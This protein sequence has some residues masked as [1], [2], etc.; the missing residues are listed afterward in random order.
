V[1]GVD[2]DLDYIRWTDDIP[3]IELVI[4]PVLPAFCGDVGTPYETAEI[5][6]ERYVDVEDLGLFADE[7]RTCR[8]AGDATCGPKCIGEDR[9]A[10]GEWLSDG[11]A[12]ARR[13]GKNR[14]NSILAK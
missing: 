14:C 1:P 8:H 7:W 13:E 9:L 4:V 11:V 6:D 12:S 10:G 2:A 3:E 5:D